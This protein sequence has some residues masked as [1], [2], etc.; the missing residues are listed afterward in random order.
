LI[1][2]VVI[3]PHQRELATITVWS[4]EEALLQRFLHVLDTTIPVPVVEKHVNPVVRGK[5]DLA[6]RPRRVA[7]VKAP[8]GL[9]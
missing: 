3:G 1:L 6:L 5:V 7:L 8:P 2:P 9:L 4:V